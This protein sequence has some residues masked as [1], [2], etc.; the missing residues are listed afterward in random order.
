MEEAIHIENVVSHNDPGDGAMAEQRMLLN[1]ILNSSTEGIIVL[2]LARQVV[3]TNPA[4]LKLL[5]CPDDNK[6]E[7]SPMDVYLG[8][9]SRRVI[10]KNPYIHLLEEGFSDLNAQLST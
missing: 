1:A 7:G 9:I 6:V 5:G 3:F 8:P 10:D 2:N 4:A